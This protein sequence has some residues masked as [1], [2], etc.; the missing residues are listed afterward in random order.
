VGIQAEILQWLSPQ[1]SSSEHIFWITGFAGSGKSTLSATLVDNLRKKGTP[2]AAQFFISREIP[3]TIDPAKI[4]PTIA[5]QLAEFSPA[6]ARVIHDTLRKDGFPS[7]RE[8]QVQAL[9]LAPI[10]ELSQSPTE[11]I[12]LID[13]L[14]ELQDAAKS[15]PE[16]LSLIA[17]KDCDLPDNVRFVI[18]SRS[19]HWAN[20]SEF[21]NFEPTVLKLHA[22]STESSREE[23][24][25]FIAARVEEITPPDW[26]P[27]PAPEDLQ[28][29]Y[30]KADGR[31]HYAA[32]ALH[33]IKDQICN[34]GEA[35]KNT[36]FDKFTLMGL[37]ELGEL[38]KATNIAD[39]EP[40]STFVILTPADGISY[41]Q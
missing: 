12:I 15:V 6:A 31:F 37:G 14:D 40:I 32:T 20:I 7:S 1:T 11:V 34:D 33:W 21:K 35:C 19:E 25:N 28:K 5:Q 2:V 30:N 38:Y 27:W 9:L 18:T 23:V 26:K 3:E 8:E 36:V 22:I 29:L 4:I 13:A 41:V 24:N 17:P 16:I 10:R 39:D